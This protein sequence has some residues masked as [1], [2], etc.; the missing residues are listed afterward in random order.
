[1]HFVDFINKQNDGKLRG[2]E[3]LLATRKK[4]MHKEREREG[5]GEYHK[6]E[7]VKKNY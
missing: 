2:N 4:E 3:E 7:N 5:G 1:M 6:L